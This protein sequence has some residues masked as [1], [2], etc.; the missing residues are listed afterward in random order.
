MFQPDERY[1]RGLEGRYEYS[2]HFR[3]Y[4]SDTAANTWNS[5][6]SSSS[7]YLARS[8]HGSGTLHQGLRSVSAD[9]DLPSGTYFVLCK[10]T[11]ER[12]ISR[13]PSGAVVNTY[14]HRRAKLLQAGQNFDLACAKGKRRDLEIANKKRAKE[15]AKAKRN[16]EKARNRTRQQERKK[17]EKKERERIEKERE[18][19]K[20]VAFWK[21]VHEKAASKGIVMPYTVPGVSPSSN[22]ADALT[23]LNVKSAADLK[24]DEDVGND[25][26]KWDPEIDGSV[27]DDE[28]SSD[29]ANDLYADDPWNAICVLGLRVYSQNGEAMI[30]VFQGES[31]GDVDV[32]DKPRSNDQGVTATFGPADDGGSRAQGGAQSSDTKEGALGPGGR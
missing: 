32:Q 28:K 21:D 6:S 20:E 29:D 27:S 18:R 17:R 4:S 7:K 3:I 12:R 14:K 31:G 9:L 15:E 5:S 22:L 26:F 16:E 30:K 25:D 1:F 24:A 2:L 11:S 19:R 8:M 23:G 10:V 13:V